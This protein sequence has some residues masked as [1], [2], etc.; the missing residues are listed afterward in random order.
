MRAMA[1]QVEVSAPLAALANLGERRSGATLP[2]AFLASLS[3]AGSHSREPLQDGPPARAAGMPPAVSRPRLTPKPFSRGQSS[4]SFAMVRP[5]I[6]SLKSGPGAMKA[7]ALG[8]TSEGTLEAVGLAGKV[9]PL[10]DHQAAQSRSPQEMVANVPFCSGSPANT[11]ILFESGRPEPG[12]AKGAPEEASSQAAKAEATHRRPEGA[13]S[14]HRQLSLSSE[15]RPASWNPRRPVERKE[16]FSGVLEEQEKDV[17]KQPGREEHHHQ[18]RP[19]TRPVSVFFLESLKEPKPA[20]PEVPGGPS[21][22]EKPW[23]RKPRPLSMDLTSRFESRELSLQRKPSLLEGTERKPVAHVARAADTRALRAG[24]AAGTRTPD[25]PSKSESPGGV[26]AAADSL[27]AKSQAV[28]KPPPS[29]PSPVGQ[30]LPKAPSQ[31][32]A[33][34]QKSLWEQKLKNQPEEPKERE[35]LMADPSEKSKEPPR[36]KGPPAPNWVASGR[37]DT[38]AASKTAAEALG[39]GNRGWTA[40][41]VHW[42]APCPEAEGKPPAGPASSLESSEKGSRVLN[43]QQRIRELTDE[44][45]ETKP[46]PLRRSFRSRPLSADLTKLFSSPAAAG[47]KAQPE[48]QPESNRK[49]A[50]EAEDIHEKEALPSCEAGCREG[51]SDG[52]PRKPQQA[53][54][55][56]LAGGHPKRD[57]SPGKERQS[58]DPQPIDE[59]TLALSREVKTSSTLPARSVAIKTVRATLF[60]HTVQRLSV[61]ARHLGPEPPWPLGSELVGGQSGPSLESRVERV[62]DAG[63]SSRTLPS[64]QADTQAVSEEPKRAKPVGE[65]E[66]PQV[67][68]LDKRNVQ[69]HIDHSVAKHVEESLMYQRIEPRYE[70]LQTIGER[71][72]SEA[73]VAVPGDKAVTLHSKMSLKEQ[74]GAGSG[75]ATGPTWPQ[76]LDTNDV[77]KG[78]GFISKPNPAGE[79]AAKTRA[80]KELNASHTQAAEWSKNRARQQLQPTRKGSPFPERTKD[81]V[82]PEDRGSRLPSETEKGRSEPLLAGMVEG[83]ARLRGLGVWPGGR[84]SSEGATAGGNQGPFLMSERG[85]QPPPR[86]VA[87]EQRR[88]GTE[89]NVT[90]EEPGSRMSGPR[91]SPA[92]CGPPE[93]HALDSEAGGPLIQPPDSVGEERPRRSLHPASSPRAL[94]RWRRRTLP[95][96]AASF[97]ETVKPLARRDSLQ[98]QEGALARRSPRAR[99]EGEPK[100][101]SGVRSPRSPSEGKATYFA[102]TCQRP[103][104]EKGNVSRSPREAPQSK[105]APSLP[106]ETRRA[107][108]ADSPPGAGFQDIMR[109]SLDGPLC[110]GREGPTEETPGRGAMA[111]LPAQARAGS[112][113]RLE[114]AEE[115][116]PEV[117]PR[118]L[119]HLRPLQPDSRQGQPMHQGHGES[120]GPAVES[121]RSRVLDLDLLMAAYQEGSKKAALAPE[122]G[123]VS[124]SQESSRWPW[125]QRAPPRSPAERGSR[126]G[127]PGREHS[128]GIHRQEGSP[129]EPSPLQEGETSQGDWSQSSSPAKARETT[130]IPP[131]WG[132][133]AA[134][135]PKSLPS[136]HIG[137]RKKTFIL[138]DEPAEALRS[139][140]PGTRGA[141]RGPVGVAGESPPPTPPSSPALARGSLQKGTSPKPQAEACSEE[142]WH[143]SL[144]TRRA[145]ASVPQD[146]SIAHS[147]AQTHGPAK[148]GLPSALA[149]LRRSYSE[150]VHQARGRTSLPP[151]TPAREWQV[152]EGGG[153]AQVSPLEATPIQPMSRRSIGPWDAPISAG[154]KD[155]LKQCFGRPPTGAKDTDTLVPE[156]DSQYGTW[157]DQ[158]LSGDSPCSSFVPESPSSEGNLTPARRRLPSSWPSS[159]SSSQT[160][161]TPATDPHDASQGPRSTSLDRSSTDVELSAEGPDPPAPAMEASLDFSFLEQTSVL[162]SS[163]LKTRVQLSKRRRRQRAPLSH[164]LR[165]S[166][167]HEEEEEEEEGEEEEEEEDRQPHSVEAVVAESTWMFRDSTG[168]KLAP[169]E[170]LEGEGKPPPSEKSPFS[171][172]PRLPVFPGMDHSALKAQLRKRHEPEGT[173]GAAPAQPSRAPKSPFQA[174][175]SSG[176]MLPLGTEKEE[177]AEEPPSPQW[178]KA[179][180][181]KKRQSQYEPGVTPT[182]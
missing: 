164:S 79:G 142:R 132:R 135:V 128:L 169:R 114:G 178:L 1:T 175:L 5:P 15:V 171:P 86:R 107:Q 7:A 84:G 58:G 55:M 48:R 59:P 20:G 160:D 170:E 181:T 93:R 115:R 42:A 32:S 72:Q 173:G 89:P 131:H 85:D 52:E 38:G 12:R 13:S 75:H 125:E 145:G 45:A 154:S 165:R 120:K 87:Q 146:P 65:G 37:P 156:A 161:P 141:N 9:P 66:T 57:G 148:T 157:S 17:A 103:A 11:V 144:R 124:H 158:R 95:H 88:S 43:I 28:Q 137:T 53:S 31:V 109:G 68:P 41:S 174:G 36:S 101:G 94:D 2:P 123:E 179:L 21:E 54:K 112:W 80:S 113:V 22:P 33:K 50:S 69:C 67:S 122:R 139:W 155:Q 104:A 74:R 117:E 82:L 152:E 90:H 91:A 61:A 60:D 110:P 8:Q 151:G 40:G 39:P 182:A 62:R 126:R 147:G 3:E 136:G 56:T 163:A 14:I 149:D 180:R 35:G 70:I 102:L 44:N 150:K 111:R 118:P 167:L 16:T 98:L 46:V 119:S 153:V 172:P 30:S 71:V 127:A 166:A 47:G 168:E 100:D 140:Q 76:N 19:W 105:H 81:A 133:P 27:W 92:A 108:L 4:E 159:S 138:D 176:R 73:V 97:E 116:V 29:E 130:F 96:G 23:A 24:E 77:R 51:C 34:E 78:D 121:Y 83:P 10:V 99:P 6:P 143:W 49:P 64:R 177:R 134:E 26:G 129:V 106:D 63:E 162:D 25:P 18:P